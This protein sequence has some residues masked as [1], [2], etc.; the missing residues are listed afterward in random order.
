MVIKIL[1]TESLGVRGL[2]CSVELTDRKIFIDPGVALGW[3]RYGFLPH[4]F[5]IAVG[6]AVREKI[7][8]ELKGATD[9]VFSH[10][11]GDHCPLADP[12]PYQLGI[13]RV[14]VLLSD[15]RVWAEGSDNCPPTQQRRKQ[16][17]AGSI[18]RVWRNANGLKEGPLE[19]SLPV[20]HGEEKEA[21]SSVM[22][23]RIDDGKEVFVHASDIQLL[24]RKA[25]EKILAWKPDIVL[26]SGPPLYLFHSLSESQ[27]ETAW[28]NATELAGNVATLIIDH[29][30]LRCEEGMEW[31]KKLARTAGNRVLSAARFMG[32]ESIFLEAWRKELYEWLPVPNNWHRDYKR[33]KADFNYY[34]IKGWE[35]LIENEKI[36]PCKWYYSCPIKEF[37]DRGKLERYW[38]ENYCLV[39]NRDCARYQMEEKGLSHPDNMLPNGEIRKNL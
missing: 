28:D 24:D 18:G 39:A 21:K 9:I 19:F 6:A 2:S 12:N 23:T 32:R 33:G 1:G 34:R 25:I 27:K 11:D 17:L 36:I 13:A 3:S 5:Q 4:P 35:V 37:T 8:Q 30:L 20:P 15:C 22:M 7:I 16:E 29:H 26:A 14:K 10:F 31:L 38:I